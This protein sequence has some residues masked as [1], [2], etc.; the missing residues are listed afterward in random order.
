MWVYTNREIDSVGL[1]KSWNAG[2]VL[3]FHTDPKCSSLS[4]P[5]QYCCAF[6][7]VIGIGL[8]NW[9]KNCTT[10]DN[11]TVSSLGR[12]DRENVSMV[13]RRDLRAL[14]FVGNV[15]GHAQFVGARKNKPS[16]P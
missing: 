2:T 11:I 15:P 5:V 4:N 3:K 8:E 1:L 10:V 9:C 13:G 14:S 6:E 7:K 12:N 16:R